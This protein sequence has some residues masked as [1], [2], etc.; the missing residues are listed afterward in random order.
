MPVVAGF[1]ALGAWAI[2]SELVVPGPSEAAWTRTLGPDDGA[3]GFLRAASPE[4]RARAA[5]ASDLLLLAH[6]ALPFADALSATSGQARLRTALVDAE[7][8]ALTGAI[9]GTL[10]LTTARARPY[11][12][13]GGEHSGDAF[14]SFPSGHTAFSFT[15]ASLFCTQRGTSGW[16]NALA[17]SAALAGAATTGTLRVVADK[18]HATDVLA[19][20]LIGGLVGWLVPTLQMTKGS[21]A[22][23]S[24]APLV[25][26]TPTGF[27]VSGRF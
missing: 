1:G 22:D 16:T 25:W 24:T 27:V 21:D 17:C 10:K 4:G 6:V 2:A 8:L 14:K 9:V 18:H 11:T 20:A 15:G 26:G 12:L 7:A 3:R 13:D 19:G 23:A 5:L